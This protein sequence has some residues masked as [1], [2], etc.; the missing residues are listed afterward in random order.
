MKK[1]FTFILAVAGISLFS[2]CHKENQEATVDNTTPVAEEQTDNTARQMVVI[3][4]GANTAATKAS[5]NNVGEWYNEGENIYVYAINENSYLTTA[6]DR[7]F[8]DNDTTT[9][10]QPISTEAKESMTD[11]LKLGHTYYYGT[12]EK[13]VYSFYGYYLGYAPDT[14]PVYDYDNTT[15]ADSIKFTGA[16]INGDNDIMLALT[17]KTADA[18]VGT[19]MVNP[20]Y[21]YSEYSSRH[22]VRPNLVFKH[23]LS[24]FVFYIKRGNDNGAATSTVTVDTVQMSTYKTADFVIDKNSGRLNNPT[25]EGFIKIEGDTLLTKTAYKRFGE[26]LMPYPAGEGAYTIKISFTYNDGNGNDT[27]ATLSKTITPADVVTDPV[28]TVTAFEAGKQYLVNITLYGLE[29]IKVNVTLTEWENGGEINYDP[30]QKGDGVLTGIVVKATN[31]NSESYTLQT[32]A[33]LAEGNA[34]KDVN[35]WNTQVPDDTYT[36]VGSALLGGDQLGAHKGIK[37][38]EGKITE[39]IDE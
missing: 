21:I 18:V 14:K 28:S 4:A 24:K 10:V 25:D 2:S 34:V 6:G 17:D 1:T 31:S 22:G 35:N 8:I 32:A 16:Q 23:Q 27:T 38:A 39:I 11:S 29:L 19:T 30:D 12:A 26:S 33:P 7:L 3:G 20:T 15:K 36:F 9:L 37:V 5:V 13:D